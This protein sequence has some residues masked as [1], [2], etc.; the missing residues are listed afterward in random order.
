MGTVQN[1]LVL[2]AIVAMYTLA[3]GAIVLLLTAGVA[4]VAVDAVRVPLQIGIGV[5]AVLVGGLAGTRLLVQKG[6]VGF[7]QR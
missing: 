1:Y 7:E 2:A 4:A 6:L 5:T 3:V